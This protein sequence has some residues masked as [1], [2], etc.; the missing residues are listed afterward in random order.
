MDTT[1][2]M[3]M[4]ITGP[5]AACAFTEIEELGVAANE[6]MQSA[7]APLNATTAVASAARL[8]LLA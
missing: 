2:N 1:F 3:L 6:S 4:H 8:M 5:S 7:K